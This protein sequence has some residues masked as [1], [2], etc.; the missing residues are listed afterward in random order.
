MK[1]ISGKM[2]SYF[3]YFMGLII[4]IVLLLMKTDDISA[5]YVSDMAVKF[6]DECSVTGKISADNYQKAYEQICKVGSYNIS[7]SNDTQVAY[8]TDTNDVRYDWLTTPND[9]ILEYMY[10]SN[11][12]DSI[13]YPMKTGDTVTITVTRK[14]ASVSSTLITWLTGS[15]TDSNSIVVTNSRTIGSNGG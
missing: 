12:T 1:D 3:M 11:P 5:S 4:A 14:N 9:K 7:L 15:Q 2:F 13:D 6:V 10:D 8:P